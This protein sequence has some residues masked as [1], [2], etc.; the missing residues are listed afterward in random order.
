[1]VK[2]A[3]AKP[4]EVAM[5]QD[6]Q[7]QCIS[8]S[9]RSNPHERITH[10]G[11]VNADGTRWRLSE[12]EA[13]AGIKQDKWRFWTSG[14]GKTAWV[15]IARSAQGHEYLKTEPDR[16]QPDNLLALPQCP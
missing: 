16:V 2:L 5:A 12:E 15:V 6:V 11:G 7:I 10:I 13:I 8:K 3:V 1:L 14:G 4:W 9:D